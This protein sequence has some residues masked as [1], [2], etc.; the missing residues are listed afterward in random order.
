MWKYS[1]HSEDNVEIQWHSGDYVE[2]QW[3][4]GDYVEVQRHSGDYLEMQWHSRI[5]KCGLLLLEWKVK[6][7]KCMTFK[8]ILR[9]TL[10]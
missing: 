5:S 9:P 1:G 4:S 3:H 2:I 6:D 7:T 10:I 8:F